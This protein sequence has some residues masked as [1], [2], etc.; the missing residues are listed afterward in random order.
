MVTMSSYQDGFE[1]WK[2]VFLVAGVVLAIVQAADLLLEDTD[3]IEVRVV[4]SLPDPSVP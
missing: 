2:S 4:K 3:E 1:L